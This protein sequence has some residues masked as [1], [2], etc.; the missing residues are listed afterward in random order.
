M[1]NPQKITRDESQVIL[2]L[3]SSSIQ[4]VLSTKFKGILSYRT[5]IKSH[6]GITFAGQM[7]KKD[8]IMSSSLVDIKNIGLR[9]SEKLKL[10]LQ[11]I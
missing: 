11:R 9:K 8:F 7:S 6:M 1:K 3:L 5:V 4:Q 2:K 10:T